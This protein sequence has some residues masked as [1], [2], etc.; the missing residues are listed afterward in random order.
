MA[1]LEGVLIYADPRWLGALVGIMGVLPMPHPPTG[2]RELMLLMVMFDEV[3]KDD[4]RFMV[5]GGIIGGRCR[6]DEV[7]SAARVRV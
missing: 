1:A 7:D 2:V 3:L 5:G 4:G 6:E